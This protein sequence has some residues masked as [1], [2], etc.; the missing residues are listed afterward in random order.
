VGK[1]ENKSLLRLIKSNLHFKTA[2]NSLSVPDIHFF[3]S[4]A[5]KSSKQ[6]ALWRLK[7]RRNINGNPLNLGTD[8]KKKER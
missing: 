4:L 2:K 1:L 5:W 7:W 6:S 3:S 8:C